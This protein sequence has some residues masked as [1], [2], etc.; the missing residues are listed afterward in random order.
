[1]TAKRRRTLIRNAGIVS[2]DPDIGDLSNADIL[3][4]YDR[5]A[6]IDDPALTSI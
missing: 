3:I 1:M 6:A 5:I 2:L 4:D